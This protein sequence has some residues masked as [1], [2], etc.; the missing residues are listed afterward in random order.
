[1]RVTFTVTMTTSYN[2]LH[3]YDKYNIHIDNV[4][5]EFTHTIT[6]LNFVCILKE[7]INEQ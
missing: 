7:F 5:I 2:M 1:M 4:V 3:I 6:V